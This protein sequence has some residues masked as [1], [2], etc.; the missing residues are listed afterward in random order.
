MVLH[1]NCI[2]VIRASSSCSI[3][4][5]RAIMSISRIST[6]ACYATWYSGFRLACSSI[7]RDSVITLPACVPGGDCVITIF[8]LRIATRGTTGCTN[9]QLAEIITAKTVPWKIALIRD[10]IRVK[11]VQVHVC[12]CVCV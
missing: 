6:R 4:H 11:G 7:N 10:C 1:A 5:L 9:A 3:V 8:R 12:V 2:D